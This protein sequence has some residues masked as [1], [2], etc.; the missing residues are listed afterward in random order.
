MLCC[1]DLNPV[2]FPLGLQ[3]KTSPQLCFLKAH[4]C[5][6]SHFI[7]VITFS[8]LEYKNLAAEELMK[9]GVNL[10]KVSITKQWRSSLI[11][12]HHVSL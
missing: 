11:L 5:I 6:Y 7:I 1:M 12:I 8:L 4:L 2:T 10:H 9:G 3:R